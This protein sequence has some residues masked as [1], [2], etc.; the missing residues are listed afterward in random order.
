MR[1]FC[2]LVLLALLCGGCGGQYILTVP[3]QVAPAGGEATTV[4]R[5][6][7]NDFFVLSLAVKKA[8]VSFRVKDGTE[9]AAYTDDL[10]Y[11]GTTVPVSQKPGRYSMRVS[12]LDYEGEEIATEVPV[13]VWAKDAPV[14]A[15]D[16]DCLP[17]MGEKGATSAIQALKQLGEKA[18]VLYFTRADSS[19]HEWLHQELRAAGYPDGPILLWRRQRWHIVRT[20][21][22]R[23]PKM[24][25]EKRLVSQL[26]SLREMFP[27]IKAGICRSTLAAKAFAR[28]DMTVII[29]GGAD[30]K[31][32]QKGSGKK[33]KIIH[34]KKWA[35]LRQK[36]VL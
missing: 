23:I 21:R 3:D 33:P 14:V 15:V 28:A 7:R 6:Q 25:I 17:R 30:V 1:G 31:L 11:A 10:G 22:F 26:R 27:G 20:G 16:F 34:R 4:V 13:Y 36:D 24:V 8:A 5:L 9:R 2:W 35:S 32:H 18:N 29:I 19:H 12:H